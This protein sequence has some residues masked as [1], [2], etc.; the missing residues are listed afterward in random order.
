M[1]D[2][3]AWREY[4][5]DAPPDANVGILTGAPS[6]G[7]VVLDFDTREGPEAILG[8]TPQQLA[9]VTIVV[10]THR[11]WHVYAREPGRATNTPPG[12]SMFE[13]KAGWSSRRQA[14]TRP[15][16]RTGS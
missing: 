7:L 2:H 11:G 5:R 9:V 12:G 15:G 10:E 8:M 6:G 16:S 13:G 3:A 4:W 14:F 1:I